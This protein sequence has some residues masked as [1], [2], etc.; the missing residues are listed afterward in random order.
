MNV[1]KSLL[2]GIMEVDNVTAIIGKIIG[3]ARGIRE[4]TTCPLNGFEVRISSFSMSLESKDLSQ[5]TGKG[6]RPPEHD[7][8]GNDS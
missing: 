5:K 2:A 1:A 7:E 6:L 4:E 3:E 8:K